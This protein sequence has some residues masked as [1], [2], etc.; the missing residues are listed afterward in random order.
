MG[1]QE[2]S[3]SHHL[4]RNTTLPVSAPIA[5]HS[6]YYQPSFSSHIV[7]L[8]SLS[9]V[10]GSLK[11]EHHLTHHFTFHTPSNALDIAYTHYTQPYYPPALNQS[12]RQDCLVP[13]LRK[14]NSRD[15]HIYTRLCP[16]HTRL[17]SLFAKYICIP[18]IHK[19]RT[20]GNASL[21]SSTLSPTK[22]FQH[23]AIF[24]PEILTHSALSHLFFSSSFPLIILQSLHTA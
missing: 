1:K 24:H 19:L 13:S 17:H 2:K 9:Q 22:K 3:S 6:L 7:S 16:L 21:L 11:Q 4:Q 15:L 18:L 5:S 10:G 12:S 23:R 8:T 20:S 14:C